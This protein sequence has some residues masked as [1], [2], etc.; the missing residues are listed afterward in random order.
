MNGQNPT[1]MVVYQNNSCIQS[2]QPDNS[3]HVSVTGM[4]LPQDGGGSY[5]LYSTAKN[6]T[7]FCAASNQVLYTYSLPPSGPVCL[8]NGF[9]AWRLSN[10]LQ[11]GTT[12]PYQLTGAP[13]LTPTADPAGSPTITPTQ[14]P[15]SEPSL[16]STVA[17]TA[18]P[19]LTPTQDPSSMTLS[20]V[21][22]IAPMGSQLAY[23][24]IYYYESLYSPSQECQAPIISDEYILSGKPVSCY[25]G[26]S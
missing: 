24:H 12:L 18:A 2:F 9:P 23:V 3:Y 15:S 17:P 1:S 6:A 5:T 25:L 16:T 7:G 11:C 4:C 22:T 26:L 21:P 10:A 20:S 8:S 14:Q 19:T 13:S